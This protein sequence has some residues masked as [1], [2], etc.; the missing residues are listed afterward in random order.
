M[1][2]P[3]YLFNLK[4]KKVK[5]FFVKRLEKYYFEISI[6]AAN[7]KL[8]YIKKFGLK[9]SNQS[10]VVLLQYF[11][12]LIQKYFPGYLFA[13]HQEVESIFDVFDF[14]NFQMKKII[15]EKGE[16]LC[17]HLHMKK[18]CLEMRRLEFWKKLYFSVLSVSYPLTKHG[19]KYF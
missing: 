6:L 15:E 7:F 10:A 2:V 5:K 11:L 17:E 3:Y 12:N 18:E 13:N 1:L 14:R 4:V 19:K 8:S 9:N 16:S